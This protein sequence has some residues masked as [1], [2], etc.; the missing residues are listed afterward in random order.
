MFFANSLYL[1]LLWVERLLFRKVNSAMEKILRE[2]YCS[3][4]SGAVFSG[5]AAVLHAAREQGHKKI[6]LNQVKNWLE[7]DETYTLHKPAPWSY[8][9]NRGRR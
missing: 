9:R 3:L 2:I 1:G 6:T 8:P 4:Q 5:P 7:K